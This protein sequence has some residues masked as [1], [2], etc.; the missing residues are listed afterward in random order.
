MAVA[1]EEGMEVATEAKDRAL[2][3]RSSVY[4]AG[5]EKDE[6]GKP[7]DGEPPKPQKPVVANPSPETGPQRPNRAGGRDVPE[8]GEKRPLSRGV[9]RSPGAK[10]G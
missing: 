9:T 2:P 7:K 6:R 10:R 5:V 8:P 1:T 4:S 3:I